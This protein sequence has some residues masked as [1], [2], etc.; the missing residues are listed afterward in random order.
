M[1]DEQLN[2]ARLIVTE[3]LKA[4]KDSP[5]YGIAVLM[6]ALVEHIDNCDEKRKKQ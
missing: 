6:Q 3:W 5:V 2:Q 1:T 4:P